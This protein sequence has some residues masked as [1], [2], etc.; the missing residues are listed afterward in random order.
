ME[1]Y[2]PPAVL[3]HN[4]YRYHYVKNQSR[5]KPICVSNERESTLFPRVNLPSQCF[6]CGRRRTANENS[7]LKYI[8]QK[9]IRIYVHSYR[10]CFKEVKISLGMSESHREKNDSRKRQGDGR[11]WSSCTNSKGPTYDSFRLLSLPPTSGLQSK[12]QFQLTT[13]SPADA[14]EDQFRS[15]SLSELDTRKSTS[16]KLGIS[17][18]AP[19]SRRDLLTRQETRQYH[20]SFDNNKMKNYL[21]K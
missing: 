15:C 18:L 9:N 8:N 19:M 6:D 16:Q 11:P 20:I 17:M 3:C 1:L 5:S 10:V 4:C 21:P 13:T 7:C 12:I 14:L 2:I